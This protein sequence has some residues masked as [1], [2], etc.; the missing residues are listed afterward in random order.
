MRNP[1]E[2]AA[3][4]RRGSRRQV[5][6]L[7]VFIVLIVLVLSLR[8]ISVFFTDFLWFK[9]VHLAG[10]W[11][12]VLLA[13]IELAVFFT[14]VGALMSFI[15]LTIAQRIMDKSVPNDSASEE[16]INRYR[17]AT[18]RFPRIGRI[19]VSA[20]IGLLLG[21]G[22]SSQWQTWLL[23]RNS[24]PFGIKDPQFH[25]DASFFVFRLPFYL[26]LVH[27]VFV[28][29]TL[30]FLLT[31]GAHYLS[32]NIT[33]Q[34]KRPRVSPPVKAQLSLIL[35][36]M[37]LVK[38]FGYY[39]QR[40]QLDL[41]TRGV[42]QGA[43]YTDVHAQLPALNMLIVISLASFALLIFNIRRQGWVLPAIGVGLW[44]FLSVVLGAVYPAII[45]NFVVQPSQA[46]KE[47]PYIGR[48]IVATR[49][50][51]G[52]DGVSQQS[53]QVNDNLS[54]NQLLQSANALRAVRLWGTNTP[55]QTVNKLQDIR[56]YYQFNSIN[57][58]RYKINGVTTPVIVGIRQLN[59]AN[60]PSNSWVNQHLQYTHGYGA[61]L[62]PANQITQ[63]GNPSFAIRDVPPVST[64]GTK[65][66]TQPQV[67]Y[68][69]QVPGYV[70]ADTKQP[71]VDYQTSTGAS[72]ETS[73]AGTGGVRLSSELVK[74]AF[75]MRFGDINLLISGLITNQSKIMFNRDIQARIQKAAPFLSLGSNPYPVILS[76]KIYWV[77][78]AYTTSAYYP[79][80]QTAD[81]S[82]L[83]PA[84]GLAANSFNYV[85][86]SVKVL[87]DAYNGTMTFYVTDPT[88]PIIRSYEKMF[89]SL[90]TPASKMSQGLIN[91]L[92][93]P[94]DMFTVQAAA[95]GRY[96]ITNPTAFY[97]A[98]DAWTLAQNP[99]NGVPTST[100]QTVFGASGTSTQNARMQP[101]YELIQLPGTNTLSFCIVEAYVPVSQNDVQQNLTGMLVARSDPGHYGQ[102]IDYVTPRGQQIDGPQ[103][104][105]AR[106]NA[107]TAVSQQIS[108]L[109]QH[110]SQVQLG[111]VMMIPIQQSLLYVRPLYV[112]STQNP[113]P[114][115]KQVIV[116]YGT[117]VAME[118]TLAGAL[119]DIFGVSVPGLQGSAQVSSG[120]GS[121][122]PSVPS[123]VSLSGLASSISQASSLYDKAQAALKAGNLAQYQ[124]DVNA[125]GSLLAST[126]SLSG[127][128]QSSTG[129]SAST[130]STTLAKTAKG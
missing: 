14:L 84:S 63:D 16:L 38:A 89:P 88:D 15:S 78:N 25:L 121:G 34:G 95:F 68:G 94:N 43:S 53:F 96:H 127:F 7:G 33:T 28:A 109:D 24:V 4:H 122:G 18:S 47:L 31:T 48:N 77:Q 86:N 102:L 101:L 9:S 75:A 106:I 72:V 29:L 119:N 113:L 3:G 107:T 30:V 90:F 41:S 57:A 40:Y 21:V 70:V 8:G 112:E 19:V 52:L 62:A 118:P 71:E 67:Y 124:K 74:A 42:V 46:T 69:Q 120:V 108:L 26:F 44:A 82:A 23:F 110:G 87:V 49:Y 35:G 20:V 10:V 55:L 123:S 36:L 92:R 50:A 13:K 117:Q 116:V 58:D 61:V 45:Q 99:G 79:Y 76:G 103:L 66:I 81:T 115:I 105:N 73:Y 59:A 98:G 60:L 1:S 100:P 64:G 32:G 54:Q 65:T 97:N 39:F 126:Q 6:A 130:T 104:I 37:A 56:S 22:T 27:W 17:S 5:V 114:E 83:N 91:H 111:S 128:P 51:L 11:S 93:Y 80:S 129:S 125:L 12:S 85:R 2:M